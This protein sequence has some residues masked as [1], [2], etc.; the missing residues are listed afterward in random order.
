MLTLKRFVPP[1]LPKM[2][3]DWEKDGPN[4]IKAFND[5][6]NSVNNFLLSLEEKGALA[7][8]EAEISGTVGAGN[9]DL[10]GNDL[11]IDA[12]A[13]TYLHS[14]AD[15]VVRMMVAGS[16]HTIWNTTGLGVGIAPSNAKLEVADGTNAAGS[17]VIG[18]TCFRIGSTL[19]TNGSE[20]RGWADSTNSLFALQAVKTNVSND[21][22]VLQAAGGK[23]G[24]GVAPSYALHLNSGQFAGPNGT[25]SA[26]TYSFS[27]SGNGDTGAYL[28]AAN[29]FA[30]ASAGALAASVIHSPNNFTQ[31][32]VNNPTSGITGYTSIE[33]VANSAQGR[34]KLRDSSHTVSPG[35]LEIQPHTGGSVW[36]GVQ[37]ATST[38]ATDGFLYI[39]TCA[40]TPTG[41]PTTASGLAPLIVD[42]TNH[43][44]YFYSGGSWRDAGP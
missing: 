6:L 37:S 4:V 43:K 38:S 14:T 41:T 32:L 44:L 8:T 17:Y 20:L 13:D 7:I 3:G 9:L 22:L 36:A 42:T 18:N 30:I 33:M 25:A 15:D 27:S 19:A 1:I 21:D 28:S 11:V 39:P 40:G 16:N 2:T 24:I 5:V 29:T 35:T 26:P 34:I 10:N 12:D 23:V 31:F